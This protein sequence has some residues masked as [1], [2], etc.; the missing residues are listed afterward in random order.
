MIVLYLCQ[1]VAEILVEV[2]VIGLHIP[3]NIEITLAVVSGQQRSGGKQLTD[4]VVIV[5]TYGHAC[6][7]GGGEG[8]VLT[9]CHDVTTLLFPEHIIR[10]HTCGKT[11]V[12]GICGITNG[13]LL[14][15]VGESQCITVIVITSGHGD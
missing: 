5:V 10:V 9:E 1:R 3:V 13:S 15:K 4:V 12:V 8:D 6:L 11:V 14:L 2:P 7:V